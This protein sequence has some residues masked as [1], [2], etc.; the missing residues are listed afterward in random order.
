LGLRSRGPMEC[1]AAHRTFGASGAGG[2]RQ[3]QGTGGKAGVGPNWYWG[4]WSA[5][6]SGQGSRELVRRGAGVEGCAKGAWRFPRPGPPAPGQTK[7][8]PPEGPDRRG[9]QELLIERGFS[10]TPLRVLQSASLEKRS[11]SKMFQIRPV[12]TV[13]GRGI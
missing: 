11:Y 10:A 1:K 3:R 12:G 4:R 8:R 5:R 6:R 7:I 9:G 13:W 2:I